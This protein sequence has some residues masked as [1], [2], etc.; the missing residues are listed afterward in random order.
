MKVNNAIIYP[1][2]QAIEPTESMKNQQQKHA[3]YR[4]GGFVLIALGIG[5]DAFAAIN[6]LSTGFYIATSVL[7]LL[8]IVCHNLAAQF[9]VGV[10]KPEE[11]PK[12]SS[13]DYY[14]DN[15]ASRTS[16]GLYDSLS[17]K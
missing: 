10:D 12:A 9:K 14:N 7:V 6:H 5:V 17:D 16:R 13:Y 11:S 8:G 4:V 2:V 3:N 15:H 1:Q